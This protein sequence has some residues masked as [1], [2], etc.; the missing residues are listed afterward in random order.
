MIILFFIL[1]FALIPFLK[2]K[3]ELDK[4][5]KEFSEKLSDLKKEEN[6]L[7]KEVKKLKNK[8]TLL[9]EELNHYEKLYEISKSMEKVTDIKELAKSF[10]EVFS[11][12]L[13]LEKI[14]FYDTQLGFIYSKGIDANELDY[15][16]PSNQDEEKV[17]FLR[18]P[19][20]IKKEI[21]SF[22]V[23]K[24][25][26]DKKKNRLIEIILSQISLLYEKAKLY[27]K[28]QDL[29]RVDGLTGLFLRRYFIE[30]FK[31]EILRAKR[32]KYSIGFLM[33]DID[34]FKQY[35]DTY[36]HQIGDKILK[37]VA[38][39]VK[40]VLDP[41]D[42]AGRYGG[43]EISVFIPARNEDEVIEKAEKIRSNIE[44]KTKVTISIGISFYP[45]DSKD[46]NEIIKKADSALYE[47]KEEGKNR[48]GVYREPRKK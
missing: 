36:G 23:S 44:K 10:I 6:K 26:I 9:S 12:E 2:F 14:A 1:V 48:V 42:F 38:N 40:N 30:R 3:Y 16:V 35:N 27:I 5:K 41:S 46:I 13:G 17:N 4:K 31:E 18:F 11:L 25:I 33:C 15:F 20:F 7:N 8:V 34:N 22:I 21:V 39:E 37:K 24:G 45:K 47:A 28:V 19:I 43:E 32:Y 29:S